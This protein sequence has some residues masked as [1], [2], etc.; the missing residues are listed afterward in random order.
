MANYTSKANVVLSVNGKQAQQMLAQLEKDARRLEK[1]I[2]AAA[3][4]GDKASLKKLQR[5]LNQTNRMMDQLKGASASTERVLSRLDKATPKELNKALRQLKNELNG[6]ERGTAAW[7]AHAAKIKAVKTEIDRVNETMREQKTLSDRVVDWI[8]KWQVALVGVGAAITGLVMAGRKAVDAYAEMDQEMANVR[9]Y[10]GMTAE[11]VE[12][13]NEKFKKMDTRTSR[14]DLNKLAQEAG[15]LGKTSTEDV[16]GFVRAADK[17]NVALDDLGDG[18]TLILS[19]LTGIFGDEKRLGTEKALLSVGSVI[20][21]L[22][23]NC[24][25]SAPYLAEFASRM[26]GVG[27]QAGMTVQQIM[28]FAAVLDSNNQKLEASSTALSQ[29]IVRIYQDPAKYA[30]VAGMN[31]KKFS[32]LVRTDMNAALIEF[33]SALKQAGNMDVL[34]P[35]FKDMGENGSRAIAALSTLANHIS[36]VKSQQQVANEA[37]AEAVSIDKEFNVQNNTVLAG[38]EKAKKHI[39]EIAV[40]LGEKLQ[41]MMKFVISS[42]TIALKALSAIVDFFI[43]YRYE[44]LSLTVALASYKIAVMAAALWQERL[45]LQLQAGILWSKIATTVKKA[46]ATAVSVLKV[47]MLALTGQFKAAK[48][49]NDA[50]SVSMKGTPWGLIAAGAVLLVSAIIKLA[51]SNREAAEAAKQTQKQVENMRKEFNEWKDTIATVDKRE[52]QYAANELGRL[53]ALYKAATDEKLSREE[54]LKAVNELQS[55]YPTVFANLD[56]EIIMTGKATQ[57]YNDLREA[58]RLT[59][60]QKGSQDYLSQLYGKKREVERQMYNDGG[61]Q[62]NINFWSGKQQEYSVKKINYEM[63]AASARRLDNEYEALKLDVMARE[64]QD[65]INEA[66]EQIKAYQKRY[67]THERQVAEIEKMEEAEISAQYAATEGLS[68]LESKYGKNPA[69]DVM[70]KGLGGGAAAP[71]GGSGSGASGGGASGAPQDKFAKE[72]EWREKEEAL[73]RIAYYTGERDYIEYT[74]RMNGIA[75][76]FY[77][78]QL[79]HT[80]LS[81]SERLKIQAEYAEASMKQREFKDKQFSDQVDEFY[82]QQAAELADFFLQDQI[83]KETYDQKMEELEIRHQTSLI[84]ATKEGSKERLDAEKKLQDMLMA[85]TE[86]RRREREQLEAKYAEMKKDYFG[87]N[88]QEAQ[89]KYDADLAMLDVVYQR[90]LAAAGENASEKLRIDEAYEA[91]KLALKKKYGLLAEEDTRNA[92][93]KGIDASIEWLNSDGGKALTGTLDTMVSGMSA[94]FSQLTSGVQ[95]DLEIQTAAINKRYDAEISRAEGNSYKVKKLE[96]E[97]G[98]EIAKAKNEANRK[99]FA[100]QVIQAVAQTAQNALNAYGSAA[101]IPVVGHVLAPIAAAMAVAAGMLQV[102]NIKKQQQ[103]SEAQGYMTGGFTPKGRPDEAVGVVH[104]GEWVASQKLVNN[105]RTRPLL[106]ALDYAQRTNTIGSIRAADVS[107]TVSAPAVMAAQSQ[108]PTVVNY[109]YTTTPAPADDRIVAVL[110]RLDSR[111]N[112]PFVTVNT[113]TGDHGIRKAQEEYDRLMKNKSPKA[114]R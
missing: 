16:L 39:N 77:S 29:V 113:V 46:Y 95:A 107:R 68:N 9:K 76:E 103:A 110:D 85:Q 20:N 43:K 41:P 97:K 1:Q 2:A 13:L 37:F 23:Q 18:A 73:N 59:A 25:A 10:T 94:I 28:G 14:E 63:R 65:K 82:K 7:D 51:K 44:L 11:Q 12:T 56:K 66:E 112:E 53:E 47:V 17:I 88:P 6:I 104:A 109:N 35:M 52:E 30:R 84:A 38:L 19:K 86:R 15:R 24:S 67:E 89:K 5:E 4:A 58:I 111:L 75:V 98:K 54:R 90:E 87:D 78:Q 72:K 93:A 50:L 91:A 57:A 31:V 55:T 114:K 3:T 49:A 106:E 101:A 32:D 45:I 33:L 102:A 69:S 42:S 34:S 60:I 8:N 81:E 64:M 108:Q 21:E 105:P 36:E 71:S 26:G 99:M 80:D 100:M 62:Y 79:K 48:A 27:A 92:M 40:E 83:S 96:K 70:D 61:D 74:N 22:S